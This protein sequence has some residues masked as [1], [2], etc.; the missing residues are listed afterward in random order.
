MILLYEQTRNWR[1]RPSQT[2]E[3]SAELSA[4]C[5][6][7]GTQLIGILQ[8]KGDPSAATD[9]S[10]DQKRLTDFC[11]AMLAELL[12]MFHEYQA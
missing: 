5:E 12:R 9:L 10:D 4:V 1:P 6:A 2:V 3:R 11:V 8:A 7:V